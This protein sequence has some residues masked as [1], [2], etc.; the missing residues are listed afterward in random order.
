MNDFSSLAL[1]QR[2]AAAFRAFLHD[3]AGLQ[4]LMDGQ[5]AACWRI[6]PRN[7]KAN[8]NA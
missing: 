3:L 8:I 7:L 6:E 1:D 4:A 5:P 2:G